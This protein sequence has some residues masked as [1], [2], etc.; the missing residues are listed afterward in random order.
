MSSDDFLG[1]RRAALEDAFFHAEEERQIQKMRAEL[2]KKSGRDDLRQVSGIADDAVLD[3]LVATGV[4]GR[5]VA[6]L[7]LVPLLRVAWADGKMDERERDA[8]LAAAQGKGIEVGS[9]S[10]QLLHGWLDRAPSDELFVSWK[11]YIRELTSSLVPPQRALLKKQIL[12]FCHGVAEAAGG[13]LG[14]RKVSGA[15]EKALAEVAA[16]FE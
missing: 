1:D 16:S 11:A 8:V 2:D 4:T 6:A 14:L 3:Q 12:D 15:E 13:I 5:T 9:A 7:S 10:F